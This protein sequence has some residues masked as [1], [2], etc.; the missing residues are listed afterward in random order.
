MSEPIPEILE[1]G[2]LQALYDDH[3]SRWSEQSLGSDSR[4]RSRVW[5]DALRDP[6][7]EFLGRPGKRF[8]AR[9]VTTSWGLSGR[10]LAYLPSTL[11]LMVEVL[12]AGSLIIDDIQDEASVRRGG[13]SLHRSIGVPL[14][15]NTGNLLYCWALDLIGTCELPA[16]AELAVHRATASCMLRCHHGQALDLAGRMSRIAPADVHELVTTATSLKAGELMAFSA[17]IGARAAGAGEETLEALDRFGRDLGT[18]LQMW[19]DLG[20][21]LVP[22]RRRKAEEDLLHERPT[23]VWAWLA[24]ELE[25]QRFRAYQRRLADLSRDGDDESAFHGLCE[26]L[27]AHVQVRAKE[28]CRRF[29]RRSI[30]GLEQRLGTSAWTAGL[31]QEIERLETSYV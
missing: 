9:L 24:E 11:P 18:A 3:F 7:L 12:H 28:S 29:L 1:A 8:R 4:I 19:D 16:A 31:R 14:A 21:L 20:S 17:T 23:W 30:Q 6:A 5:K 2:S 25:A 22:D 26:E 10:D 27:A 13:E 15:I